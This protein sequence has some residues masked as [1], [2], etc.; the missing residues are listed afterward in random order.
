MAKRTR[1]QNPTVKHLLDRYGRTF[2]EELKVDVSKN[3]P[4]PLFQ[5]LSASLLFST[6][7][8]A[9]IAVSA[10]KA[11]RKQGWTTAEKLSRSTW[12]TAHGF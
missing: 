8:S 10:T 3:T 7:I 5:L 11:L 4:S 2:A 1:K 12:E 9:D 6:R